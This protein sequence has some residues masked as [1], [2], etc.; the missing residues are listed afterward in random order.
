[1][2]N[3]DNKMKIQVKT[4]R[5]ERDIEDFDVEMIT[6]WKLGRIVSA[7]TIIISLVVFIIYYIK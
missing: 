1:M 6:E 2:I 4:L 3:K 5:D 7:A